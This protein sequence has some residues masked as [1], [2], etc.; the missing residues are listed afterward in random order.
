M[1]VTLTEAAK[2]PGAPAQPTLYRMTKNKRVPG[3]LVQTSGGWRVDTGNPEWEQ[4]LGRVSGRALP[5]KISGNRV[6]AAKGKPQAPGAAKGRG[7]A[8][9]QN[10]AKG[11]GGL[12]EDEDDNKPETTSVQKAIEAKVIY[13]ARREKLKMEQD[14]IKTGAMKEEYVVKA[15]GEFWLSFIQREMIDSFSVVR[16]CMSEVK[17]LILA[18]DDTQAGKYLNAELKAAFEQ[19]AQTLQDALD[20]KEL[21]DGKGAGR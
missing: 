10:P 7:E 1:L 17:R 8:R 18:G 6:K 15:E 3:F 4:Y 13:N 9:G 11:K 20:G 5:Q 2:Q 16:R 14:E 21:D 12:G 19:T